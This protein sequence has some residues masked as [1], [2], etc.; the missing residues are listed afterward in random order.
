[1]TNKTPVELLD[2]IFLNYL[3][4]VRD[5]SADTAVDA[6]G[7]KVVLATLEKFDRLTLGDNADG[8]TAVEMA[9]KAKQEALKAKREA[10][11]REQAADHGSL[12]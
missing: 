8:L 10:Q 3:Q 12:H 1:M 4:R 9:V 7:L 6:A 5:M 11:R 2:E